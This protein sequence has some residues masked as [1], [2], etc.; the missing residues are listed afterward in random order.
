[1][2]SG[3]LWAR[4]GEVPL[5]FENGVTLRITVEDEGARLNLNALVQ[6]TVPDEDATEEEA[7]ADSVAADD[8]A[9]EYLTLV[10]RHIIDGM[11]GPAENRSYDERTIAE[12]II[13]YMDGDSVALKG[14]N[15]DAYYLGQDPPYKPR[16]GPFLSF[17]EIGLV[18]GVDPPLLEAM[19]DYLTVHPIGGHEG[20]NVNR[21]PPW[22]LS[23][24]YSGPSGDR[25]LAREGTVRS[26][27]RVRS[28]SKIVCSDVSV[29]PKR[30]VS[31]EDAGI[32]DGSFYPET[33]VPAKPRV[34][35]MVAEAH[36]GN[37]TRRLEA[38]Y[39]MRP[40]TGPQLL[41]WRRL[42]GPQ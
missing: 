13:D 32:L 14:R 24:L 27:W 17:D 4:L 10:L 21:A 16:N 22:V 41:S 19:R 1:M 42:R 8:E 7:A 11:P 23:L 3:E 12:N 38:I 20:I 33:Q 15:E 18:E 36:V 30:C 6:Q 28:Q 29:D 37:M 31:L 39:D 25:E 34:F 35:R 9:L 40:L 26:I 5:E 2:P